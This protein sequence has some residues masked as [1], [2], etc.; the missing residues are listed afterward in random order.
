MTMRLPRRTFLKGLGLSVGLPLLEAMRPATM[1]RA[2][3]A[4]AAPTRM[5]FV[6]FPN[7][8]I[9]DAWKPEKAGHDYELPETLQALAEY[10]GDFNVITGLAQDKGRAHGDGPGD[11][12]R[13]ASTFLTGAHP[14]KTSGADIRAG[15]SVDQVA[16]QQVGGM[17]KLPSLELGIEGGRNA[18]NC[19]SGYSCAYSSN[20]SWKT[21][22][23]PM[24]KEINPRLVFERMFGG[25][26]QEAAESRARRDFYRKSI[27]DL[28]AN[29]ARRLQ[30]KLGQTDRRKLDEYFTSVRE[31]EQRIV[32]AEQ[33]GT[34]ERPDFQVPTGVPKDVAEH[35]RLM[36]DLMTLAFR[37]DT[38]RIATFMLGNAGSN[39]SYGMVNVNEGHHQLSHHQNDKEKIA[40]IK[41]IDRFLAER[42]AYFLGQLKETPDGEGTLLDHSMVLY[43]SGLSDGNRHRH[44]DLP[45]VLAGRA[46]GTIETGRHLKFDREIPMNNLF[47]SMLDRVG[48]DVRGLGD[49]TGRLDGIG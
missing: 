28:V 20:I 27:L 12:A 4:H 47:L 26:G 14:V 30:E 21:E 13:C 31:L 34:K 25:G 40:K 39:R 43:G 48:A 24:A 23:T 18:G 19:D 16:A 3:P 33:H 5:A 29:D 15:I 9:M 42:F 49:S 45:L 8:A 44:D 46:N 6:F 32:R 41:R 7:G 35:I 10:R 38:T 17:T 22:S 2:N 11:H 1:L 37:T 36:F